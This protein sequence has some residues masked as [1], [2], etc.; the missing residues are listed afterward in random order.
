MLNQ[1]CKKCGNYLISPIEYSRSYCNNCLIEINEKERKTYGWIFYH[2]LNLEKKYGK[3]I[4]KGD[5]EAKQNKYGLQRIYVNIIINKVTFSFYF[6]R[7]YIHRPDITIDLSLIQ[8][9]KEFLINIINYSSKY[10]DLPLIKSKYLKKQVEGKQEV[11]Y[12][13]KGDIDDIK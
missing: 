1:H 11:Y 12:I 10:A 2:L 5:T 6:G 13:T 3:I 4:I 8:E 7:S 9:H